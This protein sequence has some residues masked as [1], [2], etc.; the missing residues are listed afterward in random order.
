MLSASGLYADIQAKTIAPDVVPF[1]P[2]YPLWSDGEAKQRWITLPRCTW[3]DTSD[4][5]QW[6]FPIGTRLYKEFQ[7]NGR[8][9]ETRLIVRVAPGP[10]GW[11][12]ATY[13]WDLGETE[14]TRTPN[15]ATNVLGTGHDVP[16]EQDCLACHGR[17]PERVLGFG[18]V[19]LSHPR[20]GVTLDVLNRSGVLTVPIAPFVAPGD[21]L[22]QD[23]LIYLHANCSHCHNDTPNGVLFFPAFDVRLRTS[24]VD[25]A[26]TG[27]FRT[28]IG[29][30]LFEFAAPGVTARIQPG[31]AGASCVTYR[32]ARRGN[33]D[34]M[35]PLATEAQDAAGLV[36][37]NDFINAL[38]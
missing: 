9:V 29:A 4:P 33:D 25:V 31:D 19:Q 2:L 32:M 18:A 22:T 20:P 35:P 36:L 13:T 14:A 24:D 17:L 16:S 6:S 21:P 27:V 7:R 30:P 10:M 38:P 3:I 1:E 8:R 23:A 15:G 26:D 34:Q 12:F 28:A 37:L 5:D 11:A